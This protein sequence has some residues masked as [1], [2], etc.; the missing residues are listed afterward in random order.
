MPENQESKHDEMCIWVDASNSAPI[1]GAIVENIKSLSKSCFGAGCKVQSISDENKN[2]FQAFACE[3]RIDLL[4]QHIEWSDFIDASNNRF[5]FNDGKRTPGH[6]LFY[7]YSYHDPA[8]KNDKEDNKD[9]KYSKFCFPILYLTDFALEEKQQPDIAFLDSSIWHRA[10]CMADPLFIVK[11][12]DR[13]NNFQQWHSQALYER[14]VSIEIL[15]YH[16]RML[17][18]QR[19]PFKAGHGF[20]NLCSWSRESKREE[21]FHE[22]LNTSPQILPRRFLL[23]DD[24]AAT[25]LRK[26]PPEQENSPKTSSF[27]PTPNEPRK[28]NKNKITN[29]SKTD[30]VWQALENIYGRQYIEEIELLCVTDINTA[31]TLDFA[32]YD[33]ILLDYLLGPGTGERGSELIRHIIGQVAENK[34]KPPLLD[35]YWIFSISA[36]PSAIQ[37][38]IASGKLPP[39]EKLYFLHPGADPINTPGLFEKCLLEFLRY[40][41]EEACFKNENILNLYVENYLKKNSEDKK[42]VNQKI[43]ETYQDLVSLLNTIEM[44]RQTQETS[45]FAQKSL[46]SHPIHQD[47][48]LLEDF[49]H[50]IFRIAHETLR[51]WDKMWDEYLTI[52]ERLNSKNAE[53][54]LTDIRDYIIGLQQAACK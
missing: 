41:Q 37:A 15:D 49:H 13:L 18:E 36:F 47:K 28:I 23:V 10:L 30:F 35:K 4:I 29:S 32:Q 5:S 52:K 31:K 44:L 16:I 6:P 2:N 21:E 9:K 7:R 1:A 34:Q 43:R 12:S 20:I 46:G 24:Y 3:N 38:E 22:A 40:Q 8:I 53:V 11:L 33:V 42:P 50:L 48:D 27:S 39:F 45:L 54:D 25:P 51:S 14:L 26:Y 17:Q 19:L